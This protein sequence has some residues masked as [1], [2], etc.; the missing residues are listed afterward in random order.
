MVF[1]NPFTLNK[2]RKL[3]RLTEKKIDSYVT[4]EFACSRAQFYILL[5]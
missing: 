4:R 3:T 5:E 1:E 2:N